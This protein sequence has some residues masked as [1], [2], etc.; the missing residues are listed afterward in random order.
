MIPNMKSS[1]VFASIS[2]KKDKIQEDLQKEVES[3]E[4]TI[5][6]YVGGVEDGK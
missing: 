2:N 1:T 6:T 5:L 4:F 3:N